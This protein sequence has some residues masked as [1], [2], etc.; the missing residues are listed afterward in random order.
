[1][2]ETCQTRLWQS[3]VRHGTTKV[4]AKPKFRKNFHYIA[5]LVDIKPRIAI[6]LAS[7]AVNANAL[8]VFRRD[9]KCASGKA[10]RWTSRM[11]YTKNAV[12]SLS[13]QLRFWG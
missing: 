2:G 6:N 5:F 8:P 10:A 3:L 7:F 12:E 13:C 4:L 9:I 1:M 11:S